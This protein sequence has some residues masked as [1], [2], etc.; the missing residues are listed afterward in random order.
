[1]INY[2]RGNIFNALHGRDNSKVYIPH[3][4]NIHNAFGSGFAYGIM[5]EAPKVKAEYHKKC[6]SH[7]QQGGVVR[8]L[9][10]QTQFVPTE[11]GTFVNMFAQTLGGD[12]PLYYNF[13]SECMT[14]V[15]DEV[16][17]KEGEIH[18]VKFGSGLAGG[19]WSFIEE[20]ITDIWLANKIPVTIYVVGEKC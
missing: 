19:N 5:Q 16:C 20:L 14:D 18:S 10:G 6:V 9:L 11:F 15:M 2:V 13:L 1:M 3:V 7:T 4:V 17:E 8:G 12:R